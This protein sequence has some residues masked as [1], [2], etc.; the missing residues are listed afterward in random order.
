MVH[1]RRNANCSGRRRHGVPPPPMELPTSLTV[2]IERSR[3]GS[4]TLAWARHLGIDG[5]LLIMFLWNPKTTGV[6]GSTARRCWNTGKAATGTSSTVPGESPP[7]R[8]SFRQPRYGTRRFPPGCAAGVRSCCSGYATAADTMSLMTTVLIATGRRGCFPAAERTSW[9]QVVEPPSR[10]WSAGAYPGGC[11][12]R[13]QVASWQVRGNSRQAG[14]LAVSALALAALFP[15][16]DTL[17][18]RDPLLG[19]RSSERFGERSRSR[20]SD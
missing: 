14:D 3:V 17:P 7:G 2:G 16:A 12:A 8:S 6:S 19:G 11:E 9:P 15:A 13:E 1:R 4:R 20:S 18:K 5:H 10:G